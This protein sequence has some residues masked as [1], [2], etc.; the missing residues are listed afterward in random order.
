MSRIWYTVL[1]TYIVLFLIT[2]YIT[3]VTNN[4]FATDPANITKITGEYDTEEKFQ[5]VKELLEEDATTYQNENNTG[6]Q[7]FNV[8]LGAIVSFLST[9][10]N[11]QQK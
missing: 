7:S 3:F 4:N 2:G 6:S 5:L 10:I 8:V 11:R 9:T 1:S